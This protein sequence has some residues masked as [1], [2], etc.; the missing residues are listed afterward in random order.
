MEK[1]RPIDVESSS[2]FVRYY[3]GGWIGWIDESPAVGAPLPRDAPIIPLLYSTAKGGG[4]YFQHIT[5]DGES[6]LASQERS[7][8][9]LYALNDGVFV[10]SWDELLKHATFG[11][12]PIGMIRNGEEVIY[13]STLAERQW[14]RGLHLD[15]V[16]FH[17][18]NRWHLRERLGPFVEVGR[19]SLNVVWQI[20]N[21]EYQ[22]FLQA[23]TNLQQGEVVGTALSRCWGM[24]TVP[25]SPCPMIAYK[26]W[27]LGFVPSPNEIVLAEQYLDYRSELEERFGVRIRTQ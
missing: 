10:L 11:C 7:G 25:N 15:R 16:S 22:S 13:G 27:S 17:A 14:R 3:S 19:T 20:F 2:D 24:Y 5:R 1:Q 9:G 18:F 23:F 26:K 6:A 8:E 21:P 12:P 4:L